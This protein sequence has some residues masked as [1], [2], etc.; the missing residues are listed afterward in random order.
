MQFFK[1]DETKCYNIFGSI[2]NQ[3]HECREHTC[4]YAWR[5]LSNFSRDSNGQIKGGEIEELLKTIK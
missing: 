2:D 5:Y 1:K 4:E 3:G